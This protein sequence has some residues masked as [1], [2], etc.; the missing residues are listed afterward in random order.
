MRR[1]E[2]ALS[3]WNEEERRFLILQ[4]EAE[5]HLAGEYVTDDERLHLAAKLETGRRLARESRGRV[6]ALLEEVGRRGGS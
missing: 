1:L 5:R 2:D 3:R 6:A 4:A